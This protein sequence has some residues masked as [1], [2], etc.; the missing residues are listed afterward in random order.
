MKMYS[1]VGSSASRRYE[2]PE[3]VVRLHCVVVVVVVDKPSGCM[4]R[5]YKFKPYFITSREKRTE[6]VEI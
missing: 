2:H 4:L 3:N 5:K 1:C 6:F